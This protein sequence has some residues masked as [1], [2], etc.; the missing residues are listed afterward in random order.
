MADENN[1]D[2]DYEHRDD[3]PLSAHIEW[4]YSILEEVVRDAP[5]EMEW[6]T[7]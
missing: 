6:L 3:L 4:H 5:Y 2:I 1:D 7:V